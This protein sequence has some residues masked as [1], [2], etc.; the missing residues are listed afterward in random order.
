VNGILFA[1][2]PA[3][4]ADNI[5]EIG[6]FLPWIGGAVAIF[7]L[8]ASLRA[9]RRKRRIVRLAMTETFWRG[10]RLYRNSNYRAHL[11]GRATKTDTHP[12]CER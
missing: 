10:Y 6:P 5:Q 8:V 4:F 11:G 1:L 3:I 7:T 2:T 9:C 12:V